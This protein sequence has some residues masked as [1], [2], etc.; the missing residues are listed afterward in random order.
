[1]DNTD[2]TIAALRLMLTRL[3]HLE[4]HA[5][6]TSTSDVCSIEMCRCGQHLRTSMLCVERAIEHLR[7]SEEAA[8]IQHDPITE[9]SLDDC[10]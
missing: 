8:L 3:N 5:D 6:R 4:R 7:E 1:M 9:E 2:W 10:E